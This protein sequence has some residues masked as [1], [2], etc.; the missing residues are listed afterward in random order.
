MVTASLSVNKEYVDSGV[1]ALMEDPRHRAIRLSLYTVKL[2]LITAV[3]TNLAVFAFT[4]A[5]DVPLARFVTV[6]I[7]LAVRKVPRYT[8]NTKRAGTEVKRAC[9]KRD[10]GVTNCCKH[11]A[12]VRW[13][14]ALSMMVLRC[15]SI[16]ST[17]QQAHPTY[18]SMRQ[19][20]GVMDTA[21]M[22]AARTSVPRQRPTCF[23][24]TRRP[25]LSASMSRAMATGSISRS[26]SPAQRQWHTHHPIIQI[27][28]CGSSR[29]C[30]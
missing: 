16:R 3:P 7:V 11:C 2:V 8:E 9:G 5:G 27:F 29:T 19:T 1:A 23:A 24:L 26:C 4:C 30:T 28:G 14:D 6:S 13:V 25:G 20:M 15:V 17:F 21:E 12:K 18:L 22:L 10:S